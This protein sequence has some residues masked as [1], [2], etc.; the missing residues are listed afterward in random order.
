MHQENKRY[1]ELAEKWLKGTITEEE[2]N[3]FSEWYDNTDNEILNIPHD[4]AGSEEEL[5]K[6]LL[7]GIKKR[8]RHSGRVVSLT[9]G[10]LAKLAVASAVVVTSTLSLLYITR[11][12][13]SSEENDP[14]VTL[15]K[16]DT[17]IPG[18]NK[19][20]LILGDGTEVILDTATSGT[21][22]ENTH[23]RV[24]K[25]DDGQLAYSRLADV[26]AP[27][28]YNTLS[29]PRGGQYAITLVDGTRVWLNSSSSI[30]FPTSFRDPERIVEL[31]GEAYFEVAHNRDKPFKVKVNDVEVK[32]LGTHFN[33]MA[34]KDETIINATLLEGAV[35]V[36]KLKETVFLNPGQQAQIGGNGKI[37]IIKNADTE[38]AI[39]WKNGFFNFNGSDIETT[40]RQIA[41]WYDIEVIYEDKITEHFNGTI[42][43]NATIEKVLKMLELTGVVRFNIQG[44][45]IFVR[46]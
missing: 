9:R 3:E 23:T 37:G 22:A 21:I 38:Q 15:A 42:L 24:I 7:S 28:S 45:K 13:L 5:R 11:E 27:V 34:Y 43:R 2:R 1:S 32:V 12:Y 14:V 33:I 39:A 6:R 19:A 4:F 26:D 31:S 10:S 17:I 30:R 46:F 25:L 36:S 35:S 40:M 44:R 20:V 29:T 18:G 8:Q 16:K 41:R